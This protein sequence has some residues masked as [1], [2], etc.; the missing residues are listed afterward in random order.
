MREAFNQRRGQFARAFGGG[1]SGRMVNS[2]RVVLLLEG[3]HY[4][5]QARVRTQ[6]EQHAVGPEAVS[7]RSSEGRESRRQP[8]KNG[9]VVIEHEFTLQERDYVNLV[10]E[11]GSMDGYGALDKESLKLIR[12]DAT[13]DTVRGARKPNPTAR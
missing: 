5:F 8:A 7:L 1:Y 9:W 10:Y 2:W 3:G 11:F 4:R 12:L 6:V 13:P